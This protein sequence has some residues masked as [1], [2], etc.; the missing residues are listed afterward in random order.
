MKWGR[1]LLKGLALRLARVFGTRRD[2]RWLSYR[3]GQAITEGHWRVAMDHARLAIA[4]D[5]TWADSYRMLGRAYRGLGDPARARAAYE[6]GVR[7][8]PDDY[9]IAMELGDLEIAQGRHAA[10]ETAFRRALALR[11]EDADVLYQVARSVGLQG[12]YA[13]STRLLERARELAPGHPWVLARL[14]AGRYAE[15]DASGAVALLT[16]AI[17]RERAQPSAHYYLAL[18]LA[19]LGRHEEGLAAVRRA[20]A[21]D[22]DDERFSSLQA[23][24]ARQIKPFGG[25]RDGPG[26]PA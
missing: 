18:A 5:P 7:L 17:E 8:V 24:L 15:G 14:G 23:D 19:E 4:A 13:E 25:E 10:A 1:L 6:E 9:R 2:A 12:R 22:P 26:S 16:E 3:A 21:L 11:P 20:V